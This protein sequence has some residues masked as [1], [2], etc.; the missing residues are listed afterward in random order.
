MGVECQSCLIFHPH[1][2]P[3][4]SRG[5]KFNFEIGSKILLMAGGTSALQ[6]H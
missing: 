4:P 5:R 1:L 3:P 2:N 6:L